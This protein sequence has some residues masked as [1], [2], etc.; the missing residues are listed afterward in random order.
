[1][2]TQNLIND[3]QAMKTQENLQ[4]PLLSSGGEK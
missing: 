4:K 1:M 3:E 2:N